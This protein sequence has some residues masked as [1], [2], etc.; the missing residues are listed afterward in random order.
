MECQLHSGSGV[1]Q[2]DKVSRIYAG[3]AGFSTQGMCY[4]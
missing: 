1:T 2:T 4:L 3:Y